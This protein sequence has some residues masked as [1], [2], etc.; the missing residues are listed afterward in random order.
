MS[1]HILVLESPKVHGLA[2]QQT[3]H[4][5][6][7]SRVFSPYI[8]CSPALPTASSPGTSQAMRRLK[9]VQHGVLKQWPGGHRPPLGRKYMSVGE[10]WRRPV[11]SYNVVTVKNRMDAVSSFLRANDKFRLWW[12]QE[13]WH[14]PTTSTLA[15]LQTWVGGVLICGL[16]FF[17]FSISSFLSQCEPKRELKYGNSLGKSVRDHLSSSTS[18]NNPAH[19][20]STM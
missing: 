1:D 2:F 5:R 15:S 9:T 17:F 4:E 3:A 20:R 7:F 18:A 12:S 13:T 16:F 10:S 6:G 8:S 19:E 11:R 14:Q